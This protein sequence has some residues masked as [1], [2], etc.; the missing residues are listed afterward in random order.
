[1]PPFY[2]EKEMGFFSGGTKT[3]VGTSVSRVLEDKMIV[4]SILTGAVKGIVKKGRIDQYVA[5]DVIRGLGIRGRSFY[6][7]GQSRYD[8]GLPMSSVTVPTEGSDAVQEILEDIEGDIVL[9]VYSFFGYLNY[10]HVAWSGINDTYSYNIVTNELEGLSIVKGW[11]VYL[12]KSKLTI[13]VALLNSI[14]LEALQAL[15]ETMD[16]VSTE[17]SETIQLDIS[18]EWTVPHLPVDTTYTEDA[19]VTSDLTIPAFDRDSDYFHASY[20]VDGITK[21]WTYRIGEGTY[22]TLDNLHELSYAPGGTYF[23]WVYFRYNATAGNVDVNDPVYK[24]SVKLCKKLGVEYDSL[25][26]S[27]HENPDIA[28]V[29]Q[30]MLYMAVPAMSENQLECRYLFKYFSDA[31]ISQ[32]GQITTDSRAEFE[33][34]FTKGMLS[35]V[36]NVFRD[37]RFTMSIGHWGIWK[38]LVTGSIGDVGFCKVETDEMPY[39]V[40][41]A[42]EHEP[43]LKVD[44]VAAVH[45][46]MKQVSDT[47]YEEIQVM[48]LRMTYF[49]Y[50]HYATVGSEEDQ[51]GILLI[52]L[53][54]A[55]MDTF[56]IIEQEALYSRGMHY[57]FNSM[58]QVKVKWY[59]TGFFQFVMVVVAVVI[60]VITSGAT[61]HELL[62]TIAEG[63]ATFSSV[64][65]SLI[66]L[67]VTE[68]IKAELFA[69]FV[70]AIGIDN[71]VILVVLS[72]AKYVF[73]K[74]GGWDLGI[75]MINAKGALNI[76]TNLIKATSAVIEDVL[77]DLNK[78]MQEFMGYT[79]KAYDALKEVE[80]SMTTHSILAPDILLGE[81]A[82]DFINRTIHGGNI[83]MV[84]IDQIST[85]VENMLKLPTFK[86]TLG[87]SIA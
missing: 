68:Y 70:K 3:Y 23:P 56:N 35:P 66:V 31:F 52:P 65:T 10:L 34:V 86:D 14:P 27:I 13:P 4:P 24:Q 50:G 42:N 2:L 22:P 37:A 76:A 75:P 8:L 38:R 6:R 64:I 9:L 47:Q 40:T 29:Q 73:Q 84:A 30:A 81:S 79:E 32:G 67:E 12:T 59:E 46:Y 58:V 48:D 83:G 78:D 43:I 28:D 1:M 44:R 39:S 80:E 25:V 55:I 26:D 33:M 5:D 7:F 72:V 85:Y 45:Y 61:I 53:D 21:Y 57:V 20:I 62:L 11:P 36:T 15:G 17:V 60:T 49:V 41:F 19:T 69:L 74:F 18:Y 51:A 63:T 54:M 16:I 77:K 82:E 71:A 87:G